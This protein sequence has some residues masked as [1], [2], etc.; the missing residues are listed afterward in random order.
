[1]EGANGRMRSSQ[2]YQ[3]VNNDDSADLNAIELG[4][5][6]VSPLQQNEMQSAEKLSETQPTSLTVKLLLRERTFE[7]TGLSPNDTVLRLK[8][9]AASAT[10]IPPQ[11]QRL[12]FTGRSLAPDDKPLSFFKIPNNASVHMFPLPVSSPAAVSAV[13]AP[14]ASTVSTTALNVRAAGSGQHDAYVDGMHTPMHFDPSVAQHG[15]EVKLWSMLLL[16]LS[17]MALFNNLSYYSAT[18]KLGSGNL[19]S[20]VF[21]LDTF[22]SALGSWVGILGLKSVRTLDLD[23]V[24]KYVRWLAIVAF[25]SITL[26]ILWVFDVVYTVKRA[27]KKSQEDAADASNQD[28]STNDPNNNSADDVEII[29]GKAI[30][31]FGIQV[32]KCSPMTSFDAF[33]TCFDNRP[34]LSPSFASSLGRLASGAQCLFTTL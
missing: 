3:R 33:S 21:V 17:T 29:D 4:D 20:T 5:V 13:A 16:F 22:T 26:R 31:S 11:R 32:T 19:D 6:T 18:G 9:F 25:C 10:E 12:I 28:N 27:I 14:G 24:R 1:M 15:R 34:R 8:E 7:I 30:I 23:D 2:Q